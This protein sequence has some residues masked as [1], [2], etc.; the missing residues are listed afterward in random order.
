MTT[1]K[2]STHAGGAGD[3]SGDSRAGLAWSTAKLASGS[4]HRLT[5]GKPCGAQLNVFVTGQPRR[6]GIRPVQRGS[7]AGF[8][9]SERA[10]QRRLRSAIRRRRVSVGTGARPVGQVRTRRMWTCYRVLQHPHGGNPSAAIPIASARLST[11]FAEAVRGQ[12]CTVSI[13]NK[14]TEPSLEKC[15]CPVATEYRR[16]EAEFGGDAARMCDRRAKQPA[17]RS[18]IHGVPSK[19]VGSTDGTGSCGV[20]TYHAAC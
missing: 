19:R 11:I 5:R 18:M 17:Q 7:S 8:R 4:I 13:G 12:R 9:R 6:G 2:R 16:R 3:C 10:P 14:Q 20:P 1:R 15:R